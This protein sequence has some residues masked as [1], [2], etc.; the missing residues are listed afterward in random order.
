MATEKK[1]VERAIRPAL[2][3]RRGLDAR[4]LAG[5]EGLRR[6]HGG[7]L[8]EP[9]LVAASV[10]GDLGLVAAGCLG[11]LQAGFSV[12]IVGGRPEPARRPLR[13]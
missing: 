6:A 9:R 4:F 13:H 1:A 8:R 12:A 3:A 5:V 7:V 11:R 10:G 2:G